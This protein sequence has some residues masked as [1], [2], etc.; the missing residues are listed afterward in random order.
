M[1]ECVNETSDYGERSKLSIF[2]ILKALCKACKFV[3]TSL[4]EVRV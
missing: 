3:F 1:S 4:P 2:Q